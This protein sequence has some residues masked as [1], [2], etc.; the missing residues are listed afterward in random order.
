MPRILYYPGDPHYVV[1]VQDLIAEKPL[2]DSVWYFCM[3]QVPGVSLDKVIDTMTVEELDHA[4]AQL[5]LLLLRMH[6]VQSKTLGSVSGGP[7]RNTFF[8]PNVSPER[9]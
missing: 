2:V 4:A 7:Y 8:P 6:T 5:K 1:T 9:S 3:E